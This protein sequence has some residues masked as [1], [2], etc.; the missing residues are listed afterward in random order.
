ML[1]GYSLTTARDAPILIQI[2][3]LKL[4]ETQYVAKSH[5][6]LM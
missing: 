3:L 1:A 2:S 5:L 6:S 4:P